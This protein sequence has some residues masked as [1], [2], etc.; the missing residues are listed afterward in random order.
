MSR[1]PGPFKAIALTIVV[2]MLLTSLPVGA[3][4]ADLVTTAQVVEQSAAADTRGRL[5]AVFL[6]DD[7]RRQMEALGVDRDEAMARLAGLSDQEIQEIAGKV[8]ELPAGQGFVAGVLIVA[9]AVLI[10]LVILDLVGVT[11][12]FTFINPI[13]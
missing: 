1:Y 8:D 6:R 11:D 7:V 4:R 12:V 3:A 10:A 2:A 5:A 13:T 9:G